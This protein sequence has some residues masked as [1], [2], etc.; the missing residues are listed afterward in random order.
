MNGERAPADMPEMARP[1]S[2]DVRGAFNDA[3]RLPP[4]ERPPRYKVDDLIA[5]VMQED[6][7]RVQLI[8]SSGVDV[9]GKNDN[10][11]SALVIAAKEG[12]TGVIGTLMQNKANPWL[13]DR[14][15]RAPMQLVVQKGHLETLAEMLK[16][17]ISPNAATPDDVRPLETAIK[18]MGTN[19]RGRE[20]FDALLGANADVN[21]KSSDNTTLVM[22]AASTDNDYALHALIVRKATIGGVSTHGQSALTVAARNNAGKAVKLLLD[23]GADV[24]HVNDDGRTASQEAAHAGFQEL[25]KTL[26]AAE[27]K[28]VE[29][30]MKT[31]TGHETSAP[32]TAKFKKRDGQKPK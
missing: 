28:Y 25:A 29:N 27:R 18:W 15:K 26:E 3:S 13:G 17:G 21:Q 10:G 11:D 4:A 24:T 9:D 5:A 30:M 31:G 12:K 23:A 6:A 8:I 16:H 2:P 7:H 1:R 20:I 14:A 19:A 22:V 32:K